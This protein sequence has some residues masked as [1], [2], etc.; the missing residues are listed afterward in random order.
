MVKS[1]T[2][3]RALYRCRMDDALS[4][5]LEASEAADI[6]EVMGALAEEI[7]LVSPISGRMVF[8]GRGV[9]LRP[10]VVW[11]ALRAG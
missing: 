3:R 1:D 2:W 11:R 7:E 6:D 4:R 5:Y 8:R 9:A 10:G